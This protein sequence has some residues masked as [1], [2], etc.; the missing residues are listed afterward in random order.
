M[1]IIFHVTATNIDNVLPRLKTPMHETFERWIKYISQSGSVSMFG[2]DS[3]NADHF[4]SISN[5]KIIQN[6]WLIENGYEY[7]K[8]FSEVEAFNYQIEHH[9]PDV[10]FS[11]NPDWIQQNRDRLNFDKKK[12]LAIWKASPIAEQSDYRGIKLGLSFNSHYLQNL[13]DNGI[14]HTAH[15]NFCFDS[16]I[17]PNFKKS[18]EEIDISFAGTYNDHMF[19]QRTSYLH[20]LNRNFSLNYRLRFYFRVA[21]Q[22]FFNLFPNVPIVM[23]P[24]TRSP[25]YFM[26]FLEVIKSSKVVFNCHSNITGE[27]KGNMRVFETLGMKSFLLTDAGKYPRYLT[28]GTDFETYKN[29]KELIDKAKYFLK[30]DK[31]RVEIA[32]NGYETLKKYYDHHLSTK[33][34]VGIFKQ[35][36]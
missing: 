23:L 14:K 26:D 4:L 5:S 6:L 22:R 15:F 30:H 2:F 17:E 34:L 36:S 33:K 32:L 25:K 18:R 35:F 1:K 3:N 20:E 16:S 24:N 11:L 13:K 31:E 29:K 10:I 19:P 7:N 21:N 12:L 8:Q 28:P 27:H 9:D